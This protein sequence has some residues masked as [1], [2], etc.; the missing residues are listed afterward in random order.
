MMEYSSVHTLVDKK[1]RNLAHIRAGN[2]ALASRPVDKKARASSFDMKA[3]A[4]K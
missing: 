1:G 2:L 3:L 4:R